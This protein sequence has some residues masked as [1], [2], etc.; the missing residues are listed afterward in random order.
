MRAVIALLVLTRIAA[1]GTP[2]VGE[3]GRIVTSPDVDEATRVAAARTL[4]SRVA[5]DDDA[6]AVAR[7]LAISDDERVRAPLIAS[8]VAAGV[9]TP[10]AR[11]PT[12]AEMQQVLAHRVEY[13][14][15]PAYTVPR[16]S[17]CAVDS[18]DADGVVTIDCEHEQPSRSPLIDESSYARLRYDGTWQKRVITS[19]TTIERRPSSLLL[20]P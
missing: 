10:A 4:A 17:E 16:A 6:K 3:L 5:G 14:A 1:A 11:V 7:R 9:L 15:V 12:H 20:A 18:T 19:F 13:K 2:L 8:L